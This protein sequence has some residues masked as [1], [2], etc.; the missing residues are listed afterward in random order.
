MT[1]AVNR[2]CVVLMCAHLEGYLEDLAEDVVD[3]LA[4]KASSP[5]HIPLDLR[6]LLF[7]TAVEKI[8]EQRR[9][10]LQTGSVVDLE[11]LFREHAALWGG[12]WTSP[13]IALDAAV[14]KS[15]LSN[16]MAN[17]I[18]QFMRVLG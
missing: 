7:Q 14:S 10:I 18:R 3:C 4:R 11:A 6:F 15:Q 17:E 2:A 12:A 16:P 5:A 9:E 13:V 8:I 1:N